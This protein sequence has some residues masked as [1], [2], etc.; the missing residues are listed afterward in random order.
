[1]AKKKKVE[2]IDVIKQVNNQQSMLYRG[3]TRELDD[4]LDIKDI[5]SKMSKLNRKFAISKR[6]EED[7][8]LNVVGQDIL[9]K[10]GITDIINQLFSSRS[11]IMNVD[12]A[13]RKILEEAYE[14]NWMMANMPPLRT[15]I[16]DFTDATL[17]PDDI[18][19]DFFKF[20]KVSGVDGVSESNIRDRLYESYNFKSI[21]KQAVGMKNTYGYAIVYTPSYASI[22]DEIIAFT[23]KKRGFIKESL[24]DD[25]DIYEAV[26]DTLDLM[27]VMEVKAGDIYEGA[28]L[29]ATGIPQDETYLI[30]NLCMGGFTDEA[31]EA[32]SSVIESVNELNGID[33]KAIKDIA[34][35]KS[36]LK[37]SYV[38]VLESERTIPIMINRK[39]AGAIYLENS[40]DETFMRRRT[41]MDLTSASAF[42]RKT[43][44]IVYNG[45]RNGNTDLNIEDAVRQ[46]LIRNVN[47][48]FLRNNKHILNTLR[49][50]LT[51]PDNT[52]KI[53]FIPADQLTLIT[54]GDDSM[55]LSRGKIQPA[56]A[57]ILSWILLDKNNIMTELFYKRPKLFASV[58]LGGLSTDINPYLTAAIEAVSKAYPEP[59]DL[60]AKPEIAYRQMSNIGRIVSPEVNGKKMMTVETLAGQV[61]PDNMLLKEDYLD[62]TSSILNIPLKL[63]ADSDKNLVASIASTDARV[64]K[65]IISE[66][67]VISPQLTN[68]A[69]K[70]YNSDFDEAEHEKFVLKCIQPKT[71]MSDSS[72]DMIEKMKQRAENVAQMLYPN[73]DK[74]QQH[75][76]TFLFEDMCGSII[77][78]PSIKKMAEAFKRKDKG[79]GDEE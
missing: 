33:V 42:N 75:I 61:E 69:M 50:I 58:D 59:R 49:D 64:A 22:A 19:G 51:V 41:N 70:L 27:D 68:L 47:R 23:E 31:K 67:I 24:Y 54:D 60:L 34:R 72:L 7:R 13:N 48:K 14:I 15:G 36:K 10:V 11:N 45:S 43:D 53:R 44:R 17:T 30:N 74:L 2:P 37:G 57:A 62:M 56:R 16:N 3:T 77:D 21:A 12:W 65:K 78:F 55:G 8:S 29:E 20:M 73:D 63:D 26:T 39:L 79:A 18:T 52:V 66:Q 76:I 71:L 25:S 35:I 6:T 4:A 28:I 9:S 40:G 38:K 46:L 32:F 1:M 5:G